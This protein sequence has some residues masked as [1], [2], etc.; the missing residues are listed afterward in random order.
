MKND[1]KKRE[2]INYYGYGRFVFVN[3]E[4]FCLFRWANDCIHCVFVSILGFIANF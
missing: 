4:V 3:F 2:R 1:F